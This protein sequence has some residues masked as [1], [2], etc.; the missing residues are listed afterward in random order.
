MSKRFA[1]ENKAQ[2]YK[3]VF[4]LVLPMALQN[5]INVGV[6]SADVIM[7]GKVGEIALSSSSLAGQIYF[8]LS[9]I[10]F[11]LTSGAAVIT[12]QYWGKKDI[13]TI[14]KV[15]GIALQFGVV[16]G[17]VFCAVSQMMPETL[18]KIFTSEPEVIESGAA[19]LK[20]VSW[21]FPLASGTLVFLNIMRSVEKVIISTV[22]YLVS[23]IFNVIFNAVFIFGLGPAPEMGVEGAAVATLLARVVEVIIVLGY[24]KFF[25][26]TIHVRMKYLLSRDKTLMGDFKV[27]ALPVVLNEL[28]WGVGM[29]AVAAVIGHM[30]SAAVA[31]NSVTQVT[32]QLS[33]VVIFGIANATAIILGRTIGENKEELARIYGDRLVKLSAILGLFAS[34]VVFCVGP[35]AKRFLTL[36]PQASEYLSQMMLIMTFYVICQA[37]DVTYIVGVFRA[38]GDTRVGLILDAVSLWGICIPLGFIAAFILELPVWAVICV[39][40]LRMIRAESFRLWSLITSML[41]RCRLLLP[42][43]QKRL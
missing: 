29:S 10:L 12:S 1:E 20:I 15:L 2:F 23:L 9:L 41:S 35:I 43:R 27:Y 33:Q 42:I 30:G 28:A 4:A 21:S 22:V 38:G 39:L 17:L 24:C 37:I 19:Y 36:S 5:L 8:I 18:M 31:A 26:Q 25:K 14:E 7:L 32:R 6:T 34:G 11:G 3:N 40:R 13:D 16:L